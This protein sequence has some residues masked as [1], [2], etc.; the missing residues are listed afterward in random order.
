M[1]SPDVAGF[2]RQR[3]TIKHIMI[4]T[5]DSFEPHSS[6]Q[7]PNSKRVYVPGHLHADVRVPMREIE[8]SPTKGFNGQTES[9]AP[10]RVY[11]CSGPWGDPQFTGTV[12]EGLPA[13]RRDWILK[14]GDVEEYTGREATPIDDGYLSEKHRGM[15]RAKRQDETSLRLEGLT[16]PRR[17]TLRAKP[18]KVVTQLA[19][20]RAGIITPEMEFIA[21]REQMKI[22]DC[23]LQIGD[24]SKDNAR[25]DLMKQHA[26]SAQNSTGNPFT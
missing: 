11:D 6:E 12:E 1:G 15:D 21:I 9:N 24:L 25:S 19:Y 23:R 16:M 18:G 17:K 10:V 4:A 5:K 20:A 22:A 3:T 26:G 2:D 14:R 13:L 8:L 7:L